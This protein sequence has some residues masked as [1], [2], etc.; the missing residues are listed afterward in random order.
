HTHGQYVNDYE[1]ATSRTSSPCPP[2][3]TSSTTGTAAA[4]A[5]SSFSTA[6]CITP[7]GA[8]SGQQQKKQVVVG[9]GTISS[10]TT[11]ATPSVGFDGKQ[12]SPSPNYSPSGAGLGI[13]SCRRPAASRQ[14]SPVQLARSW[15]TLIW[16]AEYALKFLRK[17]LASISNENR[18]GT[19]GARE[20]ARAGGEQRH[21]RS[22]RH[23][24]HH[25]HGS[26]S[27]RAA[28]HVHHLRGQFVKI[29][30]R[31]A[32]GSYRPVY[33]EFKRW[34]VLLLNEKALAGRR[35][36]F[37][38]A[39]EPSPE[40]TVKQEPIQEPDG[41]SRMTRKLSSTTATTTTAG[42]NGDTVVKKR[43]LEKLA[44]VAAA[45]LPRDCGYC[46]ICRIEYDSL[47]VHVQ[48]ESHLAFV[49]NDDNFLSLDR[50]LGSFGGGVGDTDDGDETATRF[51]SGSGGGDAVAVD[52]FFQQLHNTTTRIKLKGGK[53]QQ[54]DGQ[55]QKRKKPATTTVTVA[56]TTTAAADDELIETQQ[57]PIGDSRTT[58]EE[59]E[60]TAQKQSLP[61]EQQQQQ[62]SNAT[63]DEHVLQRQSKQC[64]R[65]KVK[66]KCSSDA[67]EDTNK[68]LA[69]DSSDTHKHT[70]SPPGATKQ[71][72]SAGRRGSVG[73]DTTQK[74]K[75]ATIGNSVIAT[76]SL[77]C[78]DSD[79]L[80]D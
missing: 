65:A 46:E 17:V 19:K 37:A 55:E 61:P 11:T 48:S 21:H 10:I 20:G 80:A 28:Q 8:A 70:Q 56:V 27:T 16:S 77:D 79:F 30:C 67:A 63:T 49:Q 66:R 62:E 44:P 4:A 15:G 32:P 78:S 42:K 52:A 25:Q 18:G 71:D 68:E 23:H 14:N 41:T 74:L 3:I 2:P 13:G 43:A 26:S 33:K 58:K 29:E 5:A 22:H 64:S 24:H 45:A 57:T 69:V 72:W 31:S 34:P 1:P 38:D 9:S 75:P 6:A 50:L 39:N 76:A 73:G 7:G 59:E 40:R 12:A 36:P 35:A 54:Q 51:G 60:E 53:Q 47:A